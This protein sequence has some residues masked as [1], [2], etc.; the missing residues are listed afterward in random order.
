MKSIIFVYV[1]MYVCMNVHVCIVIVYVY[2]FLHVCAYLWR[3]EVDVQCSFSVHSST[4]ISRQGLSLNPEIT[5]P[6]R[7]AGPT[8]QDP[9]VSASLALRFQELLCLALTENSILNSVPC[10]CMTTPNQPRHPQPWWQG[11]EIFF[12]LFWR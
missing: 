2:V 5:D 1:C 9:P 4:Y 10:A 3:S 12:I 11:C 8:S 6:A 7:L